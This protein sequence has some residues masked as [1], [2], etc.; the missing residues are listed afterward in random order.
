MDPLLDLLTNAKVVE[1]GRRA[2]VKTF[3][4]PRSRFRGSVKHASFVAGEVSF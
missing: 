1:S 3:T 2:M 4:G